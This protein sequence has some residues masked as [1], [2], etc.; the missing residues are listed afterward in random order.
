MPVRTSGVEWHVSSCTP[1][2]LRVPTRHSTL[3]VDSNNCIALF[4]PGQIRLCAM[5]VRKQFIKQ[6]FG[7]RYERFLF[8]INF[9]SYH[10]LQFISVQTYSFKDPPPPVFVVRRLY[11]KSY[12]KKYMSYGVNFWQKSLV[13][14]E[15]IFRI[16]LWKFLFIANCIVRNQQL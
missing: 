15:G 10:W 14:Q 6:F 11:T 4:F 12:W 8:H 3:H 5:S 2:T 9:I 7:W 16:I 13:Y 1:G